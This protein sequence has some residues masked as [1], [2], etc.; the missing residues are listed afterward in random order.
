MLN[1][2]L[3]DDKIVVQTVCVNPRYIGVCW[4]NPEILHFID[5]QLMVIQYTSIECIQYKICICIK[6]G[7]C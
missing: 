4:H 2:N 6:T 1:I 3:R 5:Q 7:P